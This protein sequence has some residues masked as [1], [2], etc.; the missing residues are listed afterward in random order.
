MMI[1]ITMIITCIT[2]ACRWKHRIFVENDTYILILIYMIHAGVTGKL[3]N[4]VLVVLQILTNF[5]D[6]AMLWTVRG[7]ESFYIPMNKSQL[8]PHPEIC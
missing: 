1:R 5:R 8:K 2:V 6:A 3:K 7:R 4:D